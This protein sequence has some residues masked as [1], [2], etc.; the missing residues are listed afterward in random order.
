VLEAAE[1]YRLPF[2]SAAGRANPD[3]PFTSTREARGL[4]IAGRGVVLSALRRVGDELEV[5]LVAETA[6]A[7]TAS[8]SGRAIDAARDVDLLGRSGDSIAVDA[9]GT[10]RVPLEAWQIRTVRF[11]TQL[12]TDL[13]R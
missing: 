6:H 10:L 2:V 12:H 5:R 11:R 9:D 4:R 13:L 7:T 8:I 3:A 1:A